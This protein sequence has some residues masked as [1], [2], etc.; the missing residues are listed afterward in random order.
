MKGTWNGGIIGGGRIG[1]II[2][3]GMPC[4]GGCP[5]GGPCWCITV[6]GEI[7]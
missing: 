2:I 1:I 3:G 4:C 7:E 6:E 5:P